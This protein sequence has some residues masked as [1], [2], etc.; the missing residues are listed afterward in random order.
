MENRKAIAV[1]LL[2]ILALTAGIVSLS[3]DFAKGD[4]TASTQ[5]TGSIASSFSMTAP[6]TVDLG[7]MARGTTKTTKDSLVSYISDV[8]VNIGFASSDGGK[9]KK[10]GNS[11][12][13]TNFLGIF[14]EGGSNMVTSGTAFSALPVV[15]VSTDKK[16]TYSQLIDNGDEPGNYAI[17]LTWTISAVP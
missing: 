3:T 14:P 2:M 7:T 6:A 13:L 16:V 9:M 10:V 4:T 1:S 12:L 8:P 11:K 17:T 15:T 5:V